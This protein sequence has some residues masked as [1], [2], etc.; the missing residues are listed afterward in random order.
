MKEGSRLCKEKR[1]WCT[2]YS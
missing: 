2:T 1:T